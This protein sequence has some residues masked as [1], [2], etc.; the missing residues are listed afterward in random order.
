MGLLD[1]SLV[2]AFPTRSNLS[3]E[4]LLLS[5]MPADAFAA[6]VM[7]SL[8]LTPT[9]LLLFSSLEFLTLPALSILVFECC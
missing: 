5:I 2:R 4:E 3:F 8:P 9:L 1:R 6:R 7:L